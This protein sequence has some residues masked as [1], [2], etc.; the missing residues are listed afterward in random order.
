MA[1]S[2]DDVEARGSQTREEL[3]GRIRVSLGGLAADQVLAAGA[4][5]PSAE[6]E[7]VSAPASRPPG[8][9]AAQARPEPA[10]Q[11]A[12]EP[13][14]AA[15]AKPARSATAPAGAV[16]LQAQA[17]A[18]R[19][20]ALE[21]VHNAGAIQASLALSQM[22]GREVRVSF[23]E[24]RLVELAEA[25][26]SL[27]GPEPTVCGIYVGIA[28]QLDGGVLMVLPERNLLLFHELLHR[29]PQGSCPSVAEVDQS[30]IGELGNV[31]A[32]SFITA[33]ANET[34]LDLKSRPPEL[35]LDMCQAVLDSVLIRFNRPGDRLLFTEALLFLDDSQQVACHLLLFLE[36]DSLRRLLGQLEPLTRGQG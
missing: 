31:L 16:D 19:R 3:L 34:E 21:P 11:P 25:T 28:G 29:L 10:E 13:E 4:A 9:Q 6:P 14:P 33:I 8:E 15:E 17:E 23:P 2:A 36:P 27:G 20:G 18:L 5:E 12:A 26:A 1:P 35:K 22:S 7:P 30:A 32:A 24:S